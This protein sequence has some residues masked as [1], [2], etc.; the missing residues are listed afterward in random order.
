[1]VK[2]RRDAEAPALALMAS[3]LGALVEDPDLTG[4]HARAHAQAREADRYR[5]AV[6]AHAD[7]PLLVDAHEALLGAREGLFAQSAQ[8]RSLADERLAHRL[9]APGDATAEV[10]LAPSAQAVVQLGEALDAGHRHEM[11]APIAPDLS[12]DAALLV[13]AL[14]PREGE[15]RLEQVVRA[16]CHEAI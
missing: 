2:A 8:Q 5:V 12:L 3:D 7:E 1:V 13:R 9:A 15:G 11:A 10:S 6:L 14:D 16:K 4:A